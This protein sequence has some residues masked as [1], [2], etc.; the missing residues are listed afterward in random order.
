MSNLP[1]SRDSDFRALWVVQQTLEERKEVLEL[2]RE[3]LDNGLKDS[4]ED[5]DADFTVCSLWRY[6]GLL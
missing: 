5:V 4:V 3:A 1:D 6:A 2:R